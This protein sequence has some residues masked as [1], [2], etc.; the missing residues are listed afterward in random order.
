MLIPHRRTFA[1]VILTT[2][3]STLPA[4]PASMP[5]LVSDAGSWGTSIPSP[6][7]S[8]STR[9][10]RGCPSLRDGVDGKRSHD[11]SACGGSVPGASADV[12]ERLK[13]RMTLASVRREGMGSRG[14]VGRVEVE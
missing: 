5:A 3:H 1:A 2:A 12:S 6:D 10:A 4:L 11:R 13:V 14:L 9:K 8:R 7:L